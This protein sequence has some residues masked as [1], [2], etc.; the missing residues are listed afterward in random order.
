MPA[1]L[2]SPHSLIAD[3][4][5]SLIEEING[6]AWKA[7]LKVHEKRDGSGRPSGVSARPGFWIYR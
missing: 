4:R 5:D 2:E 7:A 3:F 1:Q 6:S